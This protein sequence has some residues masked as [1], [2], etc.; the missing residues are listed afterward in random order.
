[1]LLIPYACPAFLKYALSTY[2]LD[3]DLGLEIFFKKE[4]VTEKGEV[5]FEIGY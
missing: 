3:P 2:A 1:M 4:G 5:D